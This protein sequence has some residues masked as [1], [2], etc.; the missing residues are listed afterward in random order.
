MTCYGCGGPVSDGV[1]E[2][3]HCGG[4]PHYNLRRDRVAEVRRLQTA[5]MSQE[6]KLRLLAFWRRT[7]KEAR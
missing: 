1:K 2:C 5:M 6:E 4:D 3:P 7:E